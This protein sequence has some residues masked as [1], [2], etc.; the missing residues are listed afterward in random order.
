M[1][2]GDLCVVNGKGDLGCDGE[3]NRF[4]GKRCVFIGID[5]SGLYRVALKDQ[6]RTVAA[7]PKKNVDK[8]LTEKQK[9]KKWRNAIDAKTM[10]FDRCL[11]L[12]SLRALLIEHDS[13][14]SNGGCLHII[15][16]DGNYDD[17][18][19]D[20]CIK[21]IESGDWREHHSE[22]VTEEDA[23]N[24]LSIAKQLRELTE[25]ER[26]MVCNG[27]T[28]NEDVFNFLMSGDPS[29]VVE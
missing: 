5:K 11:E 1:L 8:I 2:A 22:W 6:P 24:Q 28:M 19:I 20:Y 4:I 17:D 16:E 27:D 26:E 12:T 13:T 10:G 29:G 14:Q 25:W 7:I 21:S 18:C 9:L 15:T 23:V 3:A